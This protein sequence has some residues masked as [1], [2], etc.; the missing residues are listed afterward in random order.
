MRTPGGVAVKRIV[1]CIAGVTILSLIVLV[2]FL[3]L[4]P[5]AKAAP[6]IDSGEALFKQKQYEKALRELDQAIEYKPSIRA[7]LLRSRIH[8]ALAHWSQAGSDIE[9]AEL[10]GY[11][12]PDRDR[13]N[14][15]IDAELEYQK[16]KME[17]EIG[18]KQ[19]E[20]EI[21]SSKAEAARRDELAVE[22]FV[23]LRGIRGTKAEPNIRKFLAK[24]T[25]KERDLAL[26]T[27][28]Y[29][30]SLGGPEKLK[31]YDKPAWLVKEN[32][33][34]RDHPELFR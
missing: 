23:D 13:L 18:L 6:H 10:M 17:L 9:S 7:Y 29:L 32:K 11:S 25:P 15:R 20:G 34:Y 3:F 12:G 22:Q 2:Y 21:N 1:W 14:K 28:K 5:G 4:S 24:L 31:E 30:K 27:A 33:F 26:S 19:V 16:K 8:A